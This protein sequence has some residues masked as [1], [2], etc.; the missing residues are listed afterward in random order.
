MVVNIARGLLI[1]EYLRVTHSPSC[2]LKCN[3][4]SSS[5]LK[6]KDETNPISLPHQT[7]DAIIIAFD[8]WLGK[9]GQVIIITVYAGL[10]KRTLTM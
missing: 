6:N 9:P 3:H 5:I 10:G 4:S 8:L 7:L 2:I 1:I